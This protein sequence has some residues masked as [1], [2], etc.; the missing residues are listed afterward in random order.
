MLQCDDD[1]S[2]E[3]GVGDEYVFGCFIDGVS[4]WG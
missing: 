1:G 4:G 2:G 3:F